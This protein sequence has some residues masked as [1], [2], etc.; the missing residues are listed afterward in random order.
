MSP[1][2]NIKR[3]EQLALEDEQDLDVDDAISMLAILL[4]NPLIEGK[5]RALLELVGA[6][7]YKVGLNERVIAEVKRGC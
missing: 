2:V 4:T 5:E 1:D 3:F 7:L 6:T